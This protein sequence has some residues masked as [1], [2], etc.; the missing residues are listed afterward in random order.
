M[1]SAVWISWFGPLFNKAFDA[2]GV[3]ES[4]SLCLFIS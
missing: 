2:V 1:N 3:L 4:C